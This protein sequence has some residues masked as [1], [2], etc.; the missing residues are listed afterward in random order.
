MLRGTLADSTS[1]RHDNHIPDTAGAHAAYKVKVPLPV[2]LQA[3][4]LQ[5]CAQSAS[6]PAAEQ[7]SGKESV[8]AQSPPVT[9]TSHAGVTEV[10]EFPF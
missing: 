2:V 5:A 3:L 9:S 6:R 8:S 7:L 4:Y 10:S 1:A